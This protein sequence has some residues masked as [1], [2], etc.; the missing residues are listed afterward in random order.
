MEIYLLRHAPAGVRAPE[1]RAD[2]NLRPL[3]PGGI[4]QMRRIA[5]AMRRMNLKFDLI[6]SSP[7]KRAMQ[8]A[9]IVAAEFRFKRRLKLTEQ[10][11]PHGDAEILLERLSVLCARSRRVLLVGH[12]P[13]LGRLAGVLL[14][15]RDAAAFKLKKAGLCRLSVRRLSYGPC[16][17]LDWWLTPRLMEQM[18]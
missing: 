7:I 17:E 9:E 11:A 5:R 6:L 12:E 18:S 10:L 3:T 8:T 13:Y 16:A 2:D 15:G 14:A 4:K 1:D